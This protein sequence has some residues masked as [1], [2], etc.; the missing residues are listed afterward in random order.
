MFSKKKLKILLRSRSLSFTRDF[1]RFGGEGVFPVNGNPIHYRSGSSDT[2][3][4]YDI[5][6]KQGHKAEYWIPEA[7]QPEVILDI[8]ANIGLTAVYFAMRYPNARIYSFEPVEE[9]YKLLQK[10]TQAFENVTTLNYALGDTDGTL[11]FYASDDTKNFGGGSL[12]EIGVDTGRQ[13][14][15]SVKETSSALKELG[16]HKADLIKIDTEGAEYEIFRSMDPA[17]YKDAQWIIGE[18]HGVND[19][20]FLSMLE[21][22]FDIS[23]KKQIN[24]RLFMFNACNKSLTK[25]LSKEDARHLM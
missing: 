4:V 15:I 21:D 2:N 1:D 3:L 11:T 13:Q 12:H 14:L 17:I 19:F 5:L 16:I 10:N 20:S 24:K 18:L 25:K 7:V 6:I 23:V 22:K 8:G 9:N